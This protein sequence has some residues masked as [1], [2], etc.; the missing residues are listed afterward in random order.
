MISYT[1]SHTPIFANTLA[2]VQSAE[3]KDVAA[4]SKTA[5]AES[6]LS[7]G[8]KRSAVSHILESFIL[9]IRSNT[10]F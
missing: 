8:V 9:R 10:Q 4:V 7:M 5:A 3:T 6:K 1:A 2:T